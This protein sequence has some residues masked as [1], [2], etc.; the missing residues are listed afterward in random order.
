MNMRKVSSILTGSPVYPQE[1]IKKSS[2]L[3][4]ADVEP[5]TKERSEKGGCFYC[6]KSDDR[7]NTSDI[8]FANK[9]NDRKLKSGIQKSITKYEDE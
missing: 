7:A 6:C 9:K 5:A 4:M 3:T 1:S 8:S 2:Q